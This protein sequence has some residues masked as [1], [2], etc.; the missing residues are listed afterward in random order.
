M[1]AIAATTATTTASVMVMLLIR[2]STVPRLLSVPLRAAIS[3]TLPATF[4]VAIPAS[5]T[6]APVP[7]PVRRGVLRVPSA[8]LPICWPSVV[9][10]LG[11]S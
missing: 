2:L 1:M 4:P 10:R 7:G 5:L 8:L 9:G 6:L 3:I 11:H